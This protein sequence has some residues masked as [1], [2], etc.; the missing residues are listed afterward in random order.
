MARRRGRRRGRGRGRRGGNNFTLVVPFIG[1]IGENTSSDISFN[2]L[3][4]G[5]TKNTLAGVPWRVRKIVYSYSNSGFIL[6]DQKELPSSQPAFFQICLNSALQ[7]NIEAVASR[8]HL[9]TIMTQRGR[10]F[11]MPPNPWKEDEDRDQAI[12]TVDNISLG[13]GSPN[14]VI[15]FLIHVTLEFGNIPYS[16]PGSKLY[17]SHQSASPQASTSPFSGISLE[18]M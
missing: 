5:A 2:K 13:G 9:S 14:T 18:D 7:H 17:H 1:S 8:R 16:H 3:F 15:S 11:P 6:Q 12:I 4:I 10:L